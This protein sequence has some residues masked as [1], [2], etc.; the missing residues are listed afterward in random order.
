MTIEP[1]DLTPPP[2]SPQSAIQQMHANS[3]PGFFGR[4]RT[5]MFAGVLV[6][7][8]I[9]ITFYLIWWVIHFIDGIVTPL[10][11]PAY[12]PENMLQFGIPGLGV[13]L[14]LVALTLIGALTT[15]LLGRFFL[16][17]SD[18]VMARMPV[19][20]GIYGATKQVFETIFSS[21]GNAFRS[22]VLVEFPRTGAWC[23][24]FITATTTGEIANHAAAPL[25]NVFVPTT[26]NPTSGYLL[27]VPKKDVIELQMTVE[28]GIKMIVSGGIVTPA[29]RS[30]LANKR[31]WR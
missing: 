8:P 1:E 6:T 27:F 11:P 15:S 13:V 16:N 7:A 2:V 26:P 23:L 22:V 20:R 28:E 14:V 19:V 9:V 10:I 17:L 21:Q 12:Q 29:D 25:V 4:L 24:G 31:D 30:A 5:W 18:R 3:K